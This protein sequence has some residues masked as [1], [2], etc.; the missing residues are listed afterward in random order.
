MLVASADL[1]IAGRAGE[2][3]E[4]AVVQPADLGV[5]G[6]EAG[7]IARQM[8]ARLHRPVGH[9]DGEVGRLAEGLGRPRH[10]AL[11]GDLVERELGVLDLLER[12]DPARRVE[13]VGRHLAPDADHF[14]QQREVVDLLGEVARRDQRRRLLGQR[15]EI[16]GA[17]DRHHLGVGVEQGLQRHRRRRHPPVDHQQDRVIDPAVER[18][19]EMLRP[20]LELDILD[21]PVVDH[22]RAEQRRLGRD[23]VRQGGGGNEGERGAA[24]G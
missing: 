14:A 1:P 11:L 5:E 23:I 3:D 21:Q 19:E 22:Q 8:A 18:L 12:L 13:G 4:V 7:R 6:I 10:L 16:G 20:Q 15:R 9:R 2:D 17:A 24:G